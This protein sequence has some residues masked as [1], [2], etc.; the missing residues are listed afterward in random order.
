M[1]GLYCTTAGFALTSCDYVSQSSSGQRELPKMTAQNEERF[2]STYLFPALSHFFY[3]FF[4][5]TQAQ[6]IPGSWARITRGLQLYMIN[7]KGDFGVYS[8]SVTPGQCCLSA[9][10]PLP[11]RQSTGLCLGR[12]G[13]CQGPFRKVK[14]VVGRQG[15]HFSPSV[16]PSY[17]RVN[18]SVAYGGSGVQGNPFQAFERQSTAQ[19]CERENYC[20]QNR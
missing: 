6:W 10:P 5:F 3:F 2:T 7:D 20:A 12:G 19:L 14:E 11:A 9:R 8:G 16:L 15:N 13:G 17:S 4:F 18:Q 1:K